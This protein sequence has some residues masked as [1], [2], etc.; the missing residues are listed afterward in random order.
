MADR[1]G[2]V[3]AGGQLRRGEAA[4]HHRMD[5]ADARAGQHGDHRL[6]HHR[7]VDDDA[8][9]LADAQVLQHAAQ[10]RHLV[11]QLGVGVGARG[12]GDGAVVDQR[13]LLRRGRARRGGRGSSRPCCTRRRR[14]SGRTGRRRGRTPCPRAC[15][16]RSRARPRPRTPPGRASRRRR[17]RD[18]GSTW[19][20]SRPGR[21]SAR[22][23]VVLRNSAERARE[24][25][26]AFARRARGRPAPVGDSASPVTSLR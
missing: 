16:S 22:A 9:A 2:V 6:G 15:T 10:R 11:A 8:V 17:P 7:H 5:G 13:L 25:K 23:A 19:R 18:S 24:C 26:A 1:L 14:T 21:R 20:S 4:E 12:L 3:D